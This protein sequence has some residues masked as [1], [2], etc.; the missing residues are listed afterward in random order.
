M[1]PELLRV[2][3]DLRDRPLRSHWPF[4]SVGEGC[5]DNQL[6]IPTL[7]HIDHV[8]NLRADKHRYH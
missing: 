4:S 3:V 8:G 6:H 1:S 7:C 5:G 2:S